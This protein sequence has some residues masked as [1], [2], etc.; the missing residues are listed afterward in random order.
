MFVSVD[1]PPIIEYNPE[2]CVKEWL[3]K[4]TRHADLHPLPSSCRKA[5]QIIE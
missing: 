3:I 1:G 2:V 4:V 5:T